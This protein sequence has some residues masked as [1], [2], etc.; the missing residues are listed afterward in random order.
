MQHTTIQLNETERHQLATI[1]H[2]GKHPARV[3]TR[4][5]ILQKTDE[6]WTIEQIADTLNV[7]P[8]TVSNTRQ[9]YRQGG[10][11]RVLSDL[12][13]KPHEPALDADGEAV[14]IA[15]ACSPVPDGHDHWTLRML[16]GRLIELGIVEGISASTVHATL[17]KM[18]SN[19]GGENSGACPSWMRRS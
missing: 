19:T 7:C 10:L 1:L 8:A 6:G 12:P 4:A 14:L 17:K 5:R 3:L 18:R 2:Q 9:R 16:R 11:Q 15:T 13:P